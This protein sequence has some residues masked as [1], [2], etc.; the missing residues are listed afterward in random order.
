M[1]AETGL[2]RAPD[3]VLLEH[4]RNLGRILIT[5]DKGFG[6]LIYLRAKAHRGV[7]LL[8]IA[9]LNLTAVHAE[10]ARLLKEHNEHE[11]S[12]CLT[13]VEAGRHRIRGI[14]F[15]SQRETGARRTSKRR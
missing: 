2:S 3:E 7:V 13:V 9:P 8:R 5:R 1:A 15:R 6:R 10:L 11:L 12:R 4:S 14:P